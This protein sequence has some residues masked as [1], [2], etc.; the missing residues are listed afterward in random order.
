MGHLTGK[1][2]AMMASASGAQ[3]TPGQPHRMTRQQ[4][5]RWGQSG[6]A[7]SPVLAVRRFAIQW[8]NFGFAEEG[9]RSG[10]LSRWD[11]DAV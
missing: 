8:F 10:M 11:D 7:S 4:S 2:A 6:C 5:A 9:G 3:C 1:L